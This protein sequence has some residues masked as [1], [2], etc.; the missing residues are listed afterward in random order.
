MTNWYKQNQYILN[1]ESHS[2]TTWYSFL[3]IYKGGM[4]RVHSVSLSGTQALFTGLL[5]MFIF[6]PSAGCLVVLR[7]L[8][9]FHAPR[10]PWKQEVGA[11]RRRRWCWQ[12][13]VVSFLEWLSPLSMKATRYPAAFLLRH[14][15]Q[16]RLGQE[17]PGK[18]GQTCTDSAALHRMGFC[19][20]GGKK[21]ASRSRAAW[22]TA[23]WLC[24][25]SLILE[26]QYP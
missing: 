4:S 18:G 5:S 23:L 16:K 3:L 10:S 13:F 15:C 25:Y 2:P 19:H 1:I 7:Q 21:L 26:R 6:H 12:G 24:I 17:A 9:Q 11:R 14:I 20:Q 22:H 8:L